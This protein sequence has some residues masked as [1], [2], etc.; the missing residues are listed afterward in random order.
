MQK[1]L[2]LQKLELVV[3]EYEM[4]IVEPKKGVKTVEEDGKI[5][6]KFAKRADWHT[7]CQIILGVKQ[8]F[9]HTIQEVCQ[10]KL[11]ALYMN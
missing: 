1:A 4:K 9:E 2:I 7:S 3:E 8:H 10:V 5:L 11:L 6:G